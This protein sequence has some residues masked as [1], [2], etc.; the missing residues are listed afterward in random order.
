MPVGKKRIALFALVA[1]IFASALVLAPSRA[2]AL[3]PIVLYQK[4]FKNADG[5]YAV[6]HVQSGVVYVLGE[7]VKGAVMADSNERPAKVSFLYLDGHTITCP[8]SL[9]EDV[10]SVRNYGRLNV[11][12][13]G[14][15]SDSGHLVQ[16][17]TN[18]GVA[19]VETKNACRLTLDL[20]AKGTATCTNRPIFRSDKL[21]NLY[22][23]S[24]TYTQKIDDASKASAL[25]ETTNGGSIVVSGGTFVREGGTEA[26]API[27][28]EGT[29]VTLRG[30]SYNFYPLYVT[31]G[32]KTVATLG[33][34]VLG[35]QDSTFIEDR[36]YTVMSQDN[37][38]K[39]FNYC[40][41]GIDVFNEIYCDDKDDA[42]RLK[43]IVGGAEVKTISKT[44]RFNT[45]GGSPEPEE[46]FVKYGGKVSAPSPEVTKDGCF[47]MGWTYDNS[48]SYY[49]FD[50]M[51]VTKDLVLEAQWAAVAAKI[52]DTPYATLQDAVNA[53]DDGDTI[54]LMSDTYQNIKIP[55]G[56]ELTIDLNGHT[57]RAQTGQPAI[58]VTGKRKLTV[59]NGYVYGN[60]GD[61][62]VLAEGSDGSEVT[63][64]A[65]EKYSLTVK[66]EGAGSGASAMSALR[67]L[68]ASTVN[69]ESGT[70]SSPGDNVVV[71]ANAGACLNAS[72][73]GF[74]HG[75]DFVTADGEALRVT[76]GTAKF[77]GGWLAGRIVVDTGSKAELTGGDFNT[78]KNRG[79]VA[80][81]YAMFYDGYSY[82]V[83][84]KSAAKSNATWVVTDSDGRKLYYTKMYDAAK[85]ADALGVEYAKLMNVSFVSNGSL[86][87]TRR[88]E[89]GE[90]LGELP[91]VLCEGYTFDGWFVSKEEDPVTEGSS[92]T[93]SMSV[94]T[95]KWSEP[96]PDPEPEPEPG[97]T[98]HTV[99]FNSNGGTEVAEQ[100]VQEG[101][102]AV[103]PAT[104][105]KNNCIFAGWYNGDD[106]YDFTEAV[107]SDITLTAHWTKC[108]EVTF[109]A[110][111]GTSTE[112]QTVEE[113]KT[114]VKPADPQ[115]DGFAFA[116][117]YN[118]DNK[119]SFTEPVTGDVQLKAHWTK[120]YTVTFNSNGG[121]SVVTQL[122][123]DGERAT[124]PTDPVKD[125]AV[126]SCWQLKGEDYNFDTAVTGDIK[127]D[128]TWIDAVPRET[129]TVT[130]DPDN[131]E[132][133]AVVTVLK[134]HA[135]YEGD[136]PIKAGSIF[137]YWKDKKGDAYI[138]GTP[139]DEDIELTAEWTDAVAEYNGVG[140]A[141]LQDAI[142][143]VPV[144]AKGATVKLL[145]D[146]VSS[147]NLG[148]LSGLTIDLGGHTLT[149][150]ANT[151]AAIDAT[152]CTDLTIK[153]GKIKVADAEFGD[154]AIGIKLSG[155]T[156][157]TLDDLTVNVSSGTGEALYFDTASSSAS[158]GS[159]KG[160][161][162]TSKEGMA[163]YCGSTNLT[164]EG[165]AFVSKNNSALL[166]ESS[167]L[168][169]KGGSF[170]SEAE[171]NAD[172]RLV[173][174]LAGGT[175]TVSDGSFGGYVELNSGAGLNIN[176]GSFSYIDN[177]ADESETALTI[178]AGEFVYF[179]NLANLAKGKAFFKA[180]DGKYQV[181]DESKAWDAS[182]AWVVL[183]EDAEV[184]CEDAAEAA[185]IAY[186]GEASFYE[187]KFVADNSTV[188]TA[189]VRKGYAIN[190]LPAGEERDGYTF[191]GWYDDTTKAGTDFEP[192]ADTTLVA[193]WSKNDSGDSGDKGDDKGDGD[194]GKGDTDDKGDTDKGDGGSDD[195]KTDGDGS[196]DGK[197]DGDADGDGKTDGDR[198]DAEDKTDKTDGDKTNGD[199]TG[200]QS[201]A[202]KGNGDATGDQ[203]A[204]DKGNGGGTNKVVT[205]T[206][207]VTKRDD[208]SIPQTSDSAPVLA[209]IAFAGAIAAFLALVLRRS[210]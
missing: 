162:Y 183:G 204:A 91:E 136:A 126:F 45:N 9:N 118:G 116:G 49:D 179:D 96:K 46:Q 24:G 108:Y 65:G 119:Y 122:V 114:A 159:I 178:N 141:T 85:D 125:E 17:N 199:A 150:A 66:C 51:T 127:L 158:S 156:G 110:D 200:D 64:E 44:V 151:G 55:E 120:L 106:K 138:F 194:G 26:C 209:A 207:T 187:V 63:L 203:S 61:A 69:V 182:A 12:G 102:T 132:E 40:V 201:A 169:V 10:V 7:D 90:K 77:T 74:T 210:E 6:Y 123:K 133:K 81:G 36:T 54:V 174:V 39:S 71:V 30:G 192:T 112:S 191:D 72:G 25:F 23:N 128:A 154:N 87:E 18:Y 206:Q 94:L 35:Y 41:T 101:K 147:A 34:M 180:K 79:Y 143:A 197:S 22:V 95:G 2:E 131:G 121:S 4:D 104:P 42:E 92:V 105:T 31:Q 52:G 171:G 48:G 115:K 148:G 1:A 146:A 129:C 50:S 175:A 109:D 137:L 170:S 68:S 37:A 167:E 184:Y 58:A 163:L 135:V 181:V 16:E 177:E 13:W 29:T 193:K 57:I 113:K 165:G 176:G 89:V 202:D 149:S 130:F 208:T 157:F 103:K 88:Y 153:N 195:G 78:Y 198:S 70:Y 73:A 189:Y 3:A 86:V 56:G 53:A 82:K 21:T 11:L 185:K 186:D 5:S 168:T 142:E 124:E 140:Y 93:E 84:K 76:Q 188:K 27:R 43:T 196:D 28:N 145:K 47:L 160:G 100:T 111:G 166:A 172:D 59:T 155:C 8:S 173:A 67:I 117:W 75:G 205:T 14:E 152:G 38:Q 83:V 139:V 32:S 20:G 97:T 98:T 19:A 33:G 62:I 60:L 80:D 190:H 164:I 134:G 15:G 107:N 161:S 144:D 99:T